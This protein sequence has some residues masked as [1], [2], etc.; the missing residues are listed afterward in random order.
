MYR[1]RTLAV[2]GLILLAGTTLAACGDTEPA[3][4]ESDDTMMEETM[5]PDTMESED[6]MMEDDETMDEDDSME[7]GHSDDSMEDD[8]MMEEDEG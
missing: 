8:E 5:E 4:E 6:S 2:P 3:A 7:E 1:M